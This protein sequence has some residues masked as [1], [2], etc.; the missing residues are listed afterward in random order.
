MGVGGFA[1]D[2][3]V[4]RLVEYTG[5]DLGNEVRLLD[6]RTGTWSRSGAEIAD[7]SMHAWAVP[8]IVYD[9]AA[10][11]TVVAGA[12]RW[13]AYDATADRWEISAPEPLRSPQRMGRHGASVGPFA[14]RQVPDI[15]L[16][17]P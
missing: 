12:D 11:R 9:E 3:S 13:G 8:A 5:G 16:R 14:S 15:R 4:D 7:Y 1:Y 2:A 10:E 6:I 17:C